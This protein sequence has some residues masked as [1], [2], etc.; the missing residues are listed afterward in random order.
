VFWY[1][2]NSVDLKYCKRYFKILNTQITNPKE[3]GIVSF[4][5]VEH[6]SPWA[7]NIP[8]TFEECG[9]KG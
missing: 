8:G 4:F 1:I 7:L 2:S 5:L 9:R 6:L 3:G